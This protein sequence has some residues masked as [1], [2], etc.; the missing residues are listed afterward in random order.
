M[1]TLSKILEGDSYNSMI[2]TDSY[3][4]KGRKNSIV[5]AKNKNVITYSELQ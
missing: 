5:A 3:I 1:A 2:A 4:I